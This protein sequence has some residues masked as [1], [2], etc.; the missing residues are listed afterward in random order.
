MILFSLADTLICGS[1]RKRYNIYFKNTLFILSNDEQI[2]IL[3]SL[4]G[5][6]LHRDEESYEN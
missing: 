6:G 1:N 3:L 5:L 4:I 2:M